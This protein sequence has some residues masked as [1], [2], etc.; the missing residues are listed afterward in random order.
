[1]E[2]DTWTT[3]FFDGSRPDILKNNELDSKSF[4]PFYARDENW[5]LGRWVDTSRQLDAKTIQVFWLLIERRRKLVCKVVSGDDTYLYACYKLIIN[6][7][8]DY[9]E[10]NAK[11]QLSYIGVWPTPKNIE[12][13]VSEFLSLIHI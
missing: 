5:K 12:D 10:E 4:Q 11:A 3:L 8:P 7:F 2:G 6:Q 1:M 9:S 13:A